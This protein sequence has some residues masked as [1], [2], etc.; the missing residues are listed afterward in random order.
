M[1]SKL[2]LK[3]TLAQLASIVEVGPSACTAQ[4]VVM[5]ATITGCLL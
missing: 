3:S 2:G 5:L 1:A 4:G